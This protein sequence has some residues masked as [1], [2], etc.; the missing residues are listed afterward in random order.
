M[1]SQ[2]NA[3]KVVSLSKSFG[4]KKILDSLSFNVPNNAIAG[5]LGPNGAGKTTTLRMLL[6]LLPA[7]NGKIELLGHKIP[8]ERASALERIGAV[9][10][11]PSFIDTMTAFENLYWFGSLYLPIEKK[12]IFE[13]IEMVGLKDSVNQKFGTF[14]SG[15]KQRLGVA[16]SLLHKPELLILDEPTSGMDPSGRY[17]MREILL[18]IHEK[19][20]TS[21]FLSSHLLDEVQKLCNYVVIINKGQMVTEGFVSDILASSEERFEIRVADELIDNAKSI[22]EGARNIV[23]SLTLAPRGFI[24]DIE[25]GTSHLI[26]E[27]LV[28]AGIKVQALIPL[29]SSLE[30]TFIKLTEK[31]KGN[32]SNT[33]AKKSEQPKEPEA[34][35]KEDKENKEVK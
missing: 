4:N 17:Q 25:N 7:P 1:S 15:M 24:V 34:V 28:K 9:V 27:L 21:I 20:K 2:N 22:L 3:I 30:E 29:E 5:F 16:F 10:E 6:G 32:F 8:E 35:Q 11:N 23:K 14:S 33:H 31:N 19:E 18:N 13:V 12:R 26:N